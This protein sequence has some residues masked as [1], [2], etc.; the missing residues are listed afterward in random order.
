MIGGQ[1]PSGWIGWLVSGVA[2]V[3]LLG[4]L[5]VHPL[6]DDPGEPWIRAYTRWLF[7][8]L[9][10]A[11]IMLLVAF[12][13]RV[14]PYGLTEP[15]LLGMLLG[16]WLLVIA[17][18]YTIQQRAGIRWV[19]VSLAVLL[20]VTLYGPLSVTRISLASQGKRLKEMV[21][22]R[23]A[24]EASGALRF[25]LEHGADR[26]VAAAVP[27]KLPQVNWDSI[28]KQRYNHDSIAGEIL[29]VAGMRYV[30]YQ[31]ATRNHYFYFNAHSESAT[32]VVGFEWMIRLSA[33]DRPVLV[34]KDSLS[35][36]FKDGVARVR[37]GP[38]SALFDV[39][40]L[41][42]F[43]A[44]D[45]TIAQQ[46]V[47]VERLSVDGKLGARRAVLRIQSLNGTRMS[48]SVRVDGWQG[49]LFLGPAVNMSH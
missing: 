26:E 46:N 33:H 7:V 28:P 37:L 1:W 30:P 39:G 48:G 10:P 41:A 3:G 6:R 24:R 25:L 38:D 17:V 34:E 31:P 9:I 21:D 40:A 36:E 47:P 44:A 29:T 22:N 12:W 43:I 4:F 14:L 49:T 5:L 45:S 15:R 42:R 23:N 20:L 27:G 35:V 32:P 11:A 13:K 8:G 16:V 19:P 18:T 2:V